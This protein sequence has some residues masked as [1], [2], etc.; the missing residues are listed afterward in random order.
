MWSTRRL[1]HSYG[2]G[3]LESIRLG[4]NDP[5]WT[6][7]LAYLFD[8]SVTP[9][10]LPE[11]WLSWI[12]PGLTWIHHTKV[13]CYKTFYGRNLQMFLISKSVCPWQVFTV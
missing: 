8:E 1:F 5:F 12:G 10:S 3:L 7:T 4:R 11:S 2:P 9:I 13:Q 6:N